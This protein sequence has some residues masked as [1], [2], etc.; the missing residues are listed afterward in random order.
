MSENLL[1]IIPEQPVYIPENQAQITASGFLKSLVAENCEVQSKVSKEI[2]FVDAGGNFESVSCSMCGK[3]ISGEWWSTAM[4]EAHQ[5]HFSQLEVVVPCCKG[6]TTLNHLN[7]NWAQG[8][9]RFVLSARNPNI[10]ELDKQS[11]T[12]LE[13]ILGCKLRV[14]WAHY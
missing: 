14:V 3:E 9:A 8:F 4:N 12:K 11:I 13:Q 6:K 7:Y 2:E 10:S 1:K 5:S